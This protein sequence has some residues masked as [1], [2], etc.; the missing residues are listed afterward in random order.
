MLYLVLLCLFCMSED[1][2]GDINETLP[3]NIGT[4]LHGFEADGKKIVRSLENLAKKQTNA[5]YAV[6]FTQTCIN[7]NLLPKFT[8]FRLNDQAVQQSEEAL[9][10]R[11]HLLKEEAKKKKKVL[12]EISEKI[13]DVS[14]SYQELPIS[15]DLRQKTDSALQELTETHERVVKTRIQRKLS[16]L[17]GGDITLP[18]QRDS[19]VNLSSYV[20]T[21]DQKDFLNL[22]LNCRLYPK[23]SQQ[24]KKAEVELLYEQICDRHR[25]GNIE[26]NPDIQE[27]LSAE[28]T[29]T[30]GTNRSGILTPRL[31]QAAKQL[32]D[33]PDI[34]I[35]RADKSS[36]FVI[37]NRAD[38]LEKTDAILSDTSKFQRLRRNPIE[39]QKRDL[40]ALIDAANA[41]VDGVKFRKLS[42]RDW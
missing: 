21:Q 11:K 3:D 2:N 28:S 30:R 16:S 35:R 18:E 37:L 22:G 6:I 33:N 24:E 1:V 23:Q 15:N 25:D 19:Y 31:R 4:I 14:R 8:H 40:N 36:T 5:R 39:K 34:I 29:K 12:E 7:E 9:S 27:Q 26:V 42:A 13:A 17:Y 10:F 32:K 20:L 38:Y 41:E